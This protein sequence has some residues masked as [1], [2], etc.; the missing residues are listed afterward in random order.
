M[1][2]NFRFE[3]LPVV[4]SEAVK[5]DHV[6]VRHQIDIV[7]VACGASQDVHLEAWC[8]KNCTSEII[9]V[10]SVFQIG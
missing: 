7:L 4:T 8:E 2:A 3:V 6:N 1:G 10:K 9:L 5:P